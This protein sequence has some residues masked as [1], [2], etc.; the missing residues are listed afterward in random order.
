MTM[1]RREISR[2][3]ANCLQDEA[4]IDRIRQWYEAN[5]DASGLDSAT[6]AL[7][8]AAAMGDAESWEALMARHPR[9]AGLDAGDIAAVLARILSPERRLVDA[10][11]ER[12]QG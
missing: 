6:A 3:L 10:T 4:Q 12:T 5:P 8:F 2:I 11:P 1:P 7:L 9:L